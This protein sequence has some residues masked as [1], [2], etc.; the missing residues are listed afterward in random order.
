MSTSSANNKR[1][2]K[3][4][5]LLYIRMLCIML[6]TLY[7]SRIIL[8]ILGV[9]DF[10]IYNV[11]GGVIVLLSFITNALSG[12]SSRYITYALG[13]EDKEKIR[14][15][16]CSINL[17]QIILAVCIL[18][19]GETIGLWFVLNKLV[20]PV[21]RL[22]AALWVYQGS[23]I[24]SIVSILS[25]PYN[26]LIIGHERMGAFAYISIFE[27]IAKLL[28]VF[29]LELIHYDHLIVYALLLLCVQLIVRI[30][31]T[32]YCKIH[33]EES[34]TKLYWDKPLI[35]EIFIYSVWCSLGYL[36]V[37][38]YTQGLNIL[39]N[40]FFGPVVN[41][42]RG[43]AVQIQSAAVQLCSNFQTALN[44]QITKSY[45]SG[46]IDYMHTLVI[47]SSKYSYYLMLLVSLPIILNTPYVLHLWLGKYPEY[48]T[49]FIRITL[50][51]STIETLK[52]PILAAI[53]ATGNIKKFQ[54]VEGLC[55]LTIVPFSYIV[56]KSGVLQPIAVFI[57]YL[58]I[59]ICTQ[60][61]RIRMILPRIN[62]NINKYIKSVI[63]PVFIVSFILYPMVLSVHL[64]VNLLSFVISSL[65]CLLTSL[66]IIY[67]LGLKKDE[68]EFIQKKIR[69]ALGQKHV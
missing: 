14:K 31:Y 62:L 11:V 15:V 21:E 6:V 65:T 40:I 42:A 8:R 35:K 18:I 5:L 63:I 30:L 37:V 48:T 57:I 61:I 67:I 27:A 41:A 59:E 39:L 43:I 47:Y 44:P 25:V 24:I 33:F 32:T 3:N 51:I 69:T 64:E 7:T 68:K 10:G 38:G 53:H 23:I 4:T 36:S 1:I 46:N 2:A 49:S 17:I 60:I 54:I 55:L 20:I 29:F 45:A 22:T 58:I 9:E 19:L 50:V 13:T 34:H 12:V 28:I 56:L 26:A 66:I 52:N 16:F